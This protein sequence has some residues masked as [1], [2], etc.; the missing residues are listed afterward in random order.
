MSVLYLIDRRNRAAFAS[1][2]E[3]MYRIR[4]RVYVDGRGWQAI[5]RADKREVDQFDTDDAIYLLGLGADGNVLSGIRLLPTTGPHLM[6]D[7]FAHTVT[8][9]RVPSDERIYEMTRYFVWGNM[10]G[11]ERRRAVNEVFCGAF[12]YA[13]ARKLTHISVVCDTFFVPRL[14]DGGW[15]PHHLGLPTEYAE[16]VCAALML[17]VSSERLHLTKS[18]AGFDGPSLTFS[19]FP[20]PNADRRDDAVAA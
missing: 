8:W 19:S 13:V 1:Q 6:R 20:P 2:I 9:G 15:K 11:E 17:E 10:R 14:L 18:Q 12:E 7:V 3:E 4:H 16:G 5:A